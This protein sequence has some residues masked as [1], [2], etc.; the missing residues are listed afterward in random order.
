MVPFAKSQPKST[1]ISS[2]SGTTCTNTSGDLALDGKLD[3]S[4]LNYDINLN[5]TGPLEIDQI[6][7]TSEAPGNRT[8]YTTTQTQAGDPS[9]N[10]GVSPII[11]WL[12]ASCSMFRNPSLDY[13]LRAILLK[14]GGPGRIAVA[15]W[16][17]H[18]HHQITIQT[19]RT[20]N[21]Q[22]FLTNVFNIQ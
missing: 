20:A 19:F 21:G 4:N 7:V 17:L 9:Q 1:T 10:K 2:F 15:Y 3:V 11:P 14:L 13:D 6:I 12:F 5:F 22:L 16:D 18:G 8:I